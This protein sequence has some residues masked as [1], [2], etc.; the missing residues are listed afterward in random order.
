[1]RGK[2]IRWLC[3]PPDSPHRPYWLK[4]DLFASVTPNTEHQNLP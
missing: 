4:P 3:K 2:E 1:M